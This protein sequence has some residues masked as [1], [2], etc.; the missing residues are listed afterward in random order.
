MEWWVRFRGRFRVRPIFVLTS[1][2][3][4]IILSAPS[5]W[6]FFPPDPS[7]ESQFDGIGIRRTRCFRRAEIAPYDIRKKRPIALV[8]GRTPL[9]HAAIIWR[10][11]PGAILA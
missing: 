7:R 11:A 5:H 9:K 6:V 3:I 8:S 1:E 10:K 4:G 2:F